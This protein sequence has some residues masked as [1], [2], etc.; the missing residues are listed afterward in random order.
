M[1]LLLSVTVIYFRVIK[2][3]I[4]IYLELVLVWN[5]INFV[6]STSVSGTHLLL[7]MQT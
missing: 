6:D 5:L 4:Y 2:V 1:S 7:N 3:Y